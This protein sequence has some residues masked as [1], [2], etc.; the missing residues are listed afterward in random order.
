MKLSDIMTREEYDSWGNEDLASWI[1]RQPASWPGWE[2]IKDSIP[3]AKPD[4]AYVA[5]QYL[6]KD[7]ILWL[8]DGTRW[9]SMSD[10]HYEGEV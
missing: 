3:R 4:P 6:D 8:Y 2:V 1:A 5:D 10:Y 9:M 7:E